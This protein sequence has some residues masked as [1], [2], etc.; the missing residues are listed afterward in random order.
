LKL[1]LTAAL[2]LALA[3]AAAAPAMAADVTLVG[4]RGAAPKTVVFE[5]LTP[6]VDADYAVRGADGSSKTVHVNGVSLSALLAATNADPVYG[7]IEIARGDGTSVLVS[8]AQVLGAPAP[9]LYLDG[10]TLR[11]LRPSYGSSDANAADQIGGASLML[12]Q[13]D[14]SRL[15]VEARASKLK[16]RARKL[17]TFTATAKGAAAGE[18]HEFEWQFDDGTKGSGPTIS[19][20]FAR[21]GRYDVLVTVRTAGSTRSDPD[22]VTVQVGAP[23]VSKKQRAG[24]GTNDA[25]SA[26]DSGAADGASGSGDAAAPQKSVKRKKKTPSTAASLPTVSG[27]LLSAAAAPLESSSLAARSGQQT[28][29]STAAEGIPGAAIGAAGLFGLLGFGFMLEFGLLK[30]PS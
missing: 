11:F 10:A 28:K 22:V 24:G 18:Q 23:V 8:K 1:A 16:L 26:P 6:D 9:V 14:S 25:A 27:Q 29:A 21:R 19:H 20:R 30:R 17:V 12:R 3:L 5:S 13:T 4:P 7:G 15:Q 2:T